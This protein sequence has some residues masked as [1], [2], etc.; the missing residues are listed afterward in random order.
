[1]K[2]ADHVDK[3]RNLIHKSFSN[4]FARLGIKAKEQKDIGNISEDQK[5]KRENLDRIIRN[6][7]DETGTFAAAYE[8]ALD[9]YTFTLF[10]RIA[11]VKVME[12]H[13]MF[14]EIIT[15]RSEQGN[16]SFAHRAWLEQNRDMSGEELEGIYEFIKYEFDRLGEK[17]PLFHR[18]Y[19]YAL[20][21]YVIE[22]NEI[23]EAFNDV[24]KD[25]GIDDNIWQS[26]DILG[27]LYESYNNVKKQAH[28]AG[29]K[30]TEYDKVYLQSQVYTP[31]WVVKFLM[32]NSLGKLYLEMYPDSE[33]KEKYKI[34]NAPD[35]RV[36]DVK[37]LDEVK[38]IDP[39][40]GS[41]NFLYY[42]FDLFYDLYMDQ[43]DNYDA[44]YD[45]DDIP[46]LILENN[47]HGT[48]I[49]GRAVQIA[50]LG[51]YIKA[52]QKNRGVSIEKFNVVS[53]DFFL[54][55]YEEV[56]DIFEQEW[57]EQETKDLIKDSWED[58][59]QAYKFGSLVKT[60]KIEEKANLEI[61]KIEK[62]KKIAKGSSFSVDK[63][64]EKW[65]NWKE[66]VIPQLHK[67]VGEHGVKT[68]DSFLGIKTK[69]AIT[70]LTILNTRYDVAVANPPY[71]D[72]SDFGPELKS[73][74]GK[75][76]KK[77]YRFHTNLYASFINRCAE[78]IDGNGKLA[79]I[80]P[81]TFMYI[82][83]FEGVRQYILEK[84]H[85]N[86]FVDYSA[87][88]TNLFDGAFASAPAF[89]VLEK[90]IKTSEDAWF[91]S[92]NQYTRTPQE[93][94]KKD[95]TLTALDNYIA[96]KDDVNNYCIPQSKMKI[97]KSWPF[98]YWI[99]DSFREKFELNIVNNSL[100]VIR[101]VESSNNLRFLR[102]WWEIGKENI[103]K[104]LKRIEGWY[105][106]SKAGPF[107]KWY[108][109]LWLTIDFREESKNIISDKGNLSGKKY[110]LHE[111]IT[112]P[113][114]GSK[115]A[116]FRYLPEGHIFD[117]GSTSIFKGSFENLY[118]A[119]AFLN[120]SLSTYL[121]NCLNPT[122]NTQ[123]F[124]V[125]RLPFFT[126]DNDAVEELLTNFAKTNIDIKK[127]L[128]IFSIIETNFTQNPMIS[129]IH[130]VKIGNL[131]DAISVFLDFENHLIA[132][133]LL[134]E[135]I[136]NEKIFEIYDLTPEDKAMVIAKE[137]ESVGKLPVL[138]EAKQ[139]Y[140]KEDSATTE[141][142]LDNIQEFIENIPE[143]EFTPEE[144][145]AVT[146]GFP[147]LYQKNK[148]LEEFCTRNQINPI[149]AW[150]WFKQSNIVPEQRMNNIAMEFLA[151]LIREILMEDEDGIAPL[152]RNSGEEIL[153]SRIEKKFM[154]K[155]FS[156]AQ[157]SQFDK[158]LGRELNE[159][160]NNHF[161][162][163][164]SDHLNLFMY[165]PKTPF[166]WHI[167]SGPSHGF[168]AYIII[169]KWNRDR[170]FKLKSFYI[171]N[172]ETA[173]RNRQSDLQNDKS[174]KAQNEKDLIFRQ[175][176]ETE[177]LKTKID[178]LLA[179]DYTPVLDDGVGKNIAPL[180]KKGMLPYNVLTKGQL[181][182]YLNADW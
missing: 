113:R 68:G 86:V 82:K 57:V 100:E 115:G 138:P 106:Y 112:M 95:Y 139:A 172:R 78:L 91:I 44:E 8:K 7:I 83:T 169:Y 13:R 76:Y 45:E 163:A 35:T 85:I 56:K 60:A 132:H 151:D 18:D 137:G 129:F 21:P 79:M 159:Y 173:L 142:P 74:I 31:R 96:D 181:K 14:P 84:F 3:I 54:P 94:Y 170:L 119:I 177:T 103:S 51:L 50:Q 26:D 87:D 136:N 160:L 47:L 1:M 154:E 29:G 70:F 37:P 140:L 120:S 77:P 25:A 48:D 81:L 63:F 114:S 69:D 107:N 59:R 66:T 128:N 20:L 92:L 38:I 19:H 12:A 93:K 64:I 146:D 5:P 143:K 55:E 134:N 126:P 2:L 118:F 97:I 156:S 22:L 149:N 166:I 73:F 80:H 17:I 71:T 65:K 58:L 150:Y 105:I 148:N 67:A 121:L 131:K 90:G 43:I 101:G 130:K 155:G 34:A 28:R 32:D 158:I 157:F 111:G 99:S 135:A 123:I 124:D 127:H 9:E 6:H 171:E 108:G 122:V 182:T 110:Y 125:K 180:Q 164:L 165:L 175:L 109:N 42:A 88:A 75:N 104:E 27:W 52:M 10:N 72:S 145:K 40:T 89:Y 61:S 167:T 23:I 98:I 46:K 11:A 36:R 168:D 152:V 16:R 49:D 24:E 39:A 15:K 141:F 117:N 30:K 147:S 161:F 174:A 178:E 41:G 53:S 162:K 133:I 4:Y 116:S 153:I 144:K 102:Y 62:M 176:K 33:I 179:E